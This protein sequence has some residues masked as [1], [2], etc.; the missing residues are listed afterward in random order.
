MTSEHDQ[1]PF[2]FDDGATLSACRQYRYRLWRT[3]GDRDRR[4][5]FVG[6]NPSTADEREDDPTIRKCVGFAKRWGFG[7]IDMVNLFAWRDTDQRGL[8]T[9]PNPVGIENDCRILQ[10]F[11]GATRI[12]FAWGRGKTA[13][14]RKIIRMRVAAESAMLRYGRAERGCLGRTEDGFPRHPLMLAYETRFEPWP[15]VR[16]SDALA[17]L[18][19][20]DAES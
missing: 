6:V 3:W 19:A 9:A 11:D 14:V 7:A 15:A 17:Q 4:C 10:A 18:A 8:L 5:V 12:V 13:P 2:G 16:A 20:E 1:L